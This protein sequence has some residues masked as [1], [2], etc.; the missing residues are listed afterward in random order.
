M[1]VS[2]DASPWVLRKSVI[3]LERKLLMTGSLSNTFISSVRLF[4]LV[5]IGFALMATAVTAFMT[6]PVGAQSCAVTTYTPY[7][8][9]SQTAARGRAECPSPAYHELDV[10][11][12]EP[13]HFR[14][15]RVWAFGEDDGNKSIFDRTVYAC[16]GGTHTWYTE[17]KFDGANYRSPNVDLINSCP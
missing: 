14:P 6:A 13:L 9:G 15:D 11:L 5:A 7:N 2:G 4:I 1:D 12:K 8:S 17:V 10:R 3:N 16:N